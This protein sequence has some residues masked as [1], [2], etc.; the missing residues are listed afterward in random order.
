MPSSPDPKAGDVWD[1]NLEP[2]VGREQGGV[3]P[4]I[5]VSNEAFNQ[6]PNELYVIVPVTGTD[7]RVRLHVPLFPPEAG[8]TKPSFAL[9]DQVRS[10][11]V[12]RFLRLRGST[13]VE[14]LRHIQTL[15]AEI[16]DR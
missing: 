6:A 14:T 9:C 10:A 4:V 13:D 2:V 1:V 11:S 12:R 5:V 3:R 7:R 16:I 15:V 8:L